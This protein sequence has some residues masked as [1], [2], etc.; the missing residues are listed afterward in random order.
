FLACW[1]F[2][3]GLG[4]WSNLTP[5][6]AQRAGS[7]PLGEALAGAMILAFFS[8]AG[9]WDVSKM[10]GE[11]RDPGRVLPRALALGVSAVMALYILTSAVFLYLVPPEQLAGENFA[12][13]AGEVLFGAAG[14]GIFSA[15]VILVI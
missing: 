3:R 13:Q 14:S 11:V 10:A 4:D 1:G 6:A 5:F 8:V 2:G 9:W 12:A 15:C 7:A